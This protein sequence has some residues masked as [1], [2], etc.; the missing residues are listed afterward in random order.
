MRNHLPVPQID[1]E[2]YELEVEIEGHE[3][4]L[5]LTLDDLK[6]MPKTTIT[7][8]VMCAGNRRSDMTKVKFKICNQHSKSNKF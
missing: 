4:T 7:A 3:N 1:P 2:S 6:Q 8:T 5:I